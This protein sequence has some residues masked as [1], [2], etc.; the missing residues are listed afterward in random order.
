MSAELDGIILTWRLLWYYHGDGKLWPKLEVV[1]GDPSIN[2]DGNLAIVEEYHNLGATI[3]HNGA[4]VQSLRPA[5]SW[6][7]RLRGRKIEQSELDE[8]KMSDPMI[9][10]R[11]ASEQ[12]Y[13]TCGIVVWYP[14]TARVVLIDPAQ[15]AA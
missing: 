2:W 1:Q 11:L 12:P 7:I 15:N 6:E 4:M 13:L 8:V 14:R 5:R 9:R 3:L 10:F